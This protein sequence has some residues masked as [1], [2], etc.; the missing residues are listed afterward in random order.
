MRSTLQTETS[1]VVL[2]NAYRQQTGDVEVHAIAVSTCQSRPQHTRQMAHFRTLYRVLIRHEKHVQNH[3]T[4]LEHG[5]AND[6]CATT[7]QS[8]TINIGPT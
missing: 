2:L 5:N 7:I 8:N 3:V 1:S 4:I 6:L